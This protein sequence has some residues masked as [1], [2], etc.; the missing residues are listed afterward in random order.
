VVVDVAPVRE[1]ERAV[2]L[3]QIK[4]DKALADWDLVRLPR[5]SVMPVTDAQWQQV[6]HLGR[7]GGG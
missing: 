2:T 3:A 1:L 6:E 7:S 5:L 4:E